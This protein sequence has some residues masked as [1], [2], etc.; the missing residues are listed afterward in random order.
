MHKE[1][2]GMNAKRWNLVCA[3]LI[4]LAATLACKFCFTTANISSRKVSKDK[5][6]S[7]ATSSFG[8]QDTVYAVAQVSN[9]P[10][11]MKLKAR[12]LFDKVEGSKSGDPVPGAETTI[13]LPGSATGTFTFTPTD[14][15][16]PAGS[17]K[18][19]VSLINEDGE[20]KDQ[21]TETFSVSGS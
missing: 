2:Q 21:K 15:G 12:L 3:L 4:V 17:Y 20:Q 7:T 16:W 19:E 13:D 1:N 5:Q 8:P 10:D 14:A 6:A 11:K 9:A 18:V